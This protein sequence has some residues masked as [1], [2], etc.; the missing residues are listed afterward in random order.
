MHHLE[1]TFD[2]RLEN[3]LS[4]LSNSNQVLTAELNEMKEE[5]IRLKEAHVLK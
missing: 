4:T 1:L 2:Q 5:I 3:M